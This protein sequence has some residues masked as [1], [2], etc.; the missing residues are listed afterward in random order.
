M[1][2][3][4]WIGGETELQKGAVDWLRKLKVKAE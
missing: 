3:K 2:K 1:D 4:H